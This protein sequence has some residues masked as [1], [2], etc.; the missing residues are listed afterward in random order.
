[1]VKMRLKRM[2]MKKKPFYRI[3]VADITSPRDGR[4]IAEIGYYDPMIEKGKMREF[5]RVN[6]ALQDKSIAHIA[7]EI[8]TR[9]AQIVLVFGPSSSGKTTFAN[10]LAVQLRVLGKRPQL[11]SLDDFYKARAEA[12]IGEDGKPDLESIEAL[13]V[14]YLSDCIEQ[15]LSAETVQMP[16][17]DFVT[18]KRMPETTPMRQEPDN[19]CDCRM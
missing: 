12:P 17:F 3:V 7:D 9:N 11:V 1:M 8:V 19:A 5:V 4:N 10:R 6:E 15:L 16:R 2:G 14:G 13:D 18:G